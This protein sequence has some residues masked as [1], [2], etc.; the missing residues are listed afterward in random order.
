MARAHGDYVEIDDPK[1]PGLRRYFVKIADLSVETRPKLFPAQTDKRLR[2][3]NG[4][5]S[6]SATGTVNL[7]SGSATGEI[8]YNKVPGGAVWTINWFEDRIQTLKGESC[9]V[10]SA[11][12]IALDGFVD[13]APV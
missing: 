13:V 3:I 12:A 7:Y 6:Q 8:S 4:R 1:Y 5:I 9:E 10:D 2:A 11:E